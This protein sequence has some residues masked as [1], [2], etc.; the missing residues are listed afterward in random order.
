[1]IYTL[2]VNPALDFT[3][4]LENFEI[5]QINRT[6][7]YDFELGG[8]G[9]NVS[10]ILTVLGHE[11][12]AWGFEGGFIGREI[13]NKLTEKNIRHDFVVI[14]DNTRMNIQISAGAETA[15]NGDGPNIPPFK[16]DELMKKISIV[17][18]GD[19]VVMSGS[20][21][22]N[23]GDDFYNQ[24]ANVVKAKGAEFVVDVSGKAL[25]DAL[26]LKPFLV[27]PNLQ[28]LQDTFDVEILT[29]EDIIMYAKK[30]I[31]MGAQNVIV[32]LGGNGAYLV[33]KDQVFQAPAVTGTVVSS[34]GAGDSMVGAFVGTYQKT[35]DLEESFKYA[36]AAGAAT[37]FANIFATKDE[38]EKLLPEV[39]INQLE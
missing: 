1:M 39:K 29:E 20:I 37:T 38:I 14:K 25:L 19:M 13:M 23:L 26:S 12:L 30:M 10:Q 8:K 5:G 2:T 21:P 15:I 9:I 24:V 17:H 27:K 16:V 18:Q 36:I 6:S 11:N 34:V 7:I 31:T 28:E 33:T 4:Q 32:S 3:V 35:K 22:K